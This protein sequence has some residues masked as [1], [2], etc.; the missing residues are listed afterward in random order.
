MASQGQTPR[1]SSTQLPGA[2]FLSYITR[3]PY[4]LTSS[5]AHITQALVV[6][7]RELSANNPQA[8]LELYTGVLS[9]PDSPSH[10]AA[11][12][13][14]ALCY[15][16]LGFPHLAVT[17]AY[18]ALICAEWVI[19]AGSQDPHSQQL[20]NLAN[21]TRGADSSVERWIVQ[22]TC[23]IGSAAFTFLEEPLASIAVKPTERVDLENPD[24]EDNH[25]RALILHM[26]LDVMLKAYYRIALALRKCG[27]GAWKDANEVLCA[28]MS[29]TECSESDIGQFKDLQNAILQDIQDET[30][31]EDEMM[32]YLIENEGLSDDPETKTKYKEEGI[33]GLLKS[34]YTKVPRELYPWDNFSMNWE[35]CQAILLDLDE[36][37]EQITNGFCTLKV[38]DDASKAPQLTLYA[39]RHIRDSDQM[40]A[41]KG[42]AHVVIPSMEH[43]PD[44]NCDACGALLNVS[45]DFCAQAVKTARDL[46]AQLGKE[47]TEKEQN[48]TTNGP[49][50]APKTPQTGEPCST[51]TAPPGFQLCPQCR[52][53][54]Y[55]STTCN[56]STLPTHLSKL[57]KKNLEN[58]VQ[59]TATPAQWTGL[60]NEPSQRCL[61]LL[62]FRV[63]ADAAQ[64][65]TCPLAAANMRLLHGN[66]DNPRNLPPDG[67][68]LNAETHNLDHVIS[69]TELFP[70]R[71]TIA[72]L[73]S[74]TS[75]D[76]S[77]Q[78]ETPTAPKATTPWSYTS[79]IIQP[80]RCL[81]LLDANTEQIGGMDL[82]LDTRRFDGWMLETMRM[83]V[84]SAMRVSK[85]PRYAKLFGRAGDVEGEGCVGQSM[86]PNVYAADGDVLGAG[87]G[88]QAMGAEMQETG[89]EIAYIASLH[90]LASVVEVATENEKANVQLPEREGKISC[91]PRADLV[92][93][94][95][96]RLLRGRNVIPFVKVE[97]DLQ[98]V[99][100]EMKHRTSD[101]SAA[102][103]L[104]GMEKQLTEGVTEE[105]E[106]KEIEEDSKLGKRGREL[107][108]MY[109]ELKGRAHQGEA[110]TS[111]EL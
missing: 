47:N 84:S 69:L 3:T 72:D 60:P 65:S 43:R 108:I 63:L 74:G 40:F 86:L 34:G 70:S 104:R 55:C 42:A 46:G 79:N 11:F 82:C 54:C 81:R 90:P 77:E 94:A 9:D 80:I 6:A 17:D 50:S 51:L 14:R 7:N 110:S 92:V 57:C 78:T 103:V 38:K 73:E 37:V 29:R 67:A 1:K 97:D 5:V 22:P 19:R 13:N 83:K 4:L 93:K 18:R 30:E 98:A 21:Y 25:S 100:G 53:H 102:A 111:G 88:A 58:I 26:A 35:N 75:S 39:R 85:Y 28:A 87:S 105:G 76:P 68:P 48:S 44:F 101:S 91:M 31:A 61:N 52:L 2:T 32:V 41:E 66:L 64:H 24:D 45:P 89:D 99:L 23:F 15:I 10:S 95:G 96:E 20:L 12:L 27:G 59:T 8:A 16:Q 107:M 33:R 106:V 56:A 62:L 109:R 36:G 71:R 49:P